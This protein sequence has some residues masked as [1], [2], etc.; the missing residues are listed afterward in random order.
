MPLL[1]CPFKAQLDIVSYGRAC[2]SQHYVLFGR[3]CPSLI[4]ALPNII[5]CFGKGMPI[6]MPFHISMPF[7]ALP[8]PNMIWQSIEGHALP[9]ISICR[10]VWK[11]MPFYALPYHIGV[12]K[13]MEGHREGN[14]HKLEEGPLCFGWHGLYFDNCDRF[15]KKVLIGG[16]FPASPMPVCAPC[17]FT[18][19]WYRP[20]MLGCG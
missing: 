10:S 19:C 15:L 3:A 5:S 2:P 16:A 11:G 4:N 7:H 12:W 8:N 6:T 9:N 18:R 14:G 17:L 13:G 1:N 20:S